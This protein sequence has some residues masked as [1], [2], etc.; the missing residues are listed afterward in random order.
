MLEGLPLLLFCKLDGEKEVYEAIV[1]RVGR[2]MSE[3]KLAHS[4]DTFPVGDK[5]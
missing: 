3:E 1:V 5:I 4:T 2:E